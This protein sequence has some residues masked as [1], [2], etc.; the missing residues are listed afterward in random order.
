SRF[1]RSHISTNTDKQIWVRLSRR[2][3]AGMPKASIDGIEIYYEVHGSGPPVLLVAGL[4][5][6]GAYWHP[7][8]GPLSQHFQIIVHDHRG[9]GQSTASNAKVSV[10]RMAKDL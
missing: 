1:P 6:E 2:G 8:I 7:Q 5:G 4:G 3:G 9:T 10:E